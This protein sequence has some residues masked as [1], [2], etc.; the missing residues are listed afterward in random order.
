M[1]YIDTPNS[2]HDFASFLNMD[3]NDRII[4]S[5]GFGIGKTTFLEHYFKDVQAQEKYFICKLY[6]INYVTSENKDIYELIKYDILLQLLK[7]EIDITAE[8]LEGLNVG[9]K[10]NN[11]YFFPVLKDLAGIIPVIG[12][13]LVSAVSAIEKIKNASIEYLDK[14]P[15]DKIN[16]FL[17]E[18]QEQTGSP[19]EQ[20]DI[21]IFIK[22][23]INKIKDKGKR[24]VLI[25]DDFDRLEPAQTFRLLNILSTNDKSVVNDSGLINNENRFGFDKIIIVCDINNLRN[26]Y[27]HINGSSF[28]G[29]IDKFYSKNIYHFNPMQDLEN[30]VSDFFNMIQINGENINYFFKAYFNVLK[31]LYTKQYI[32][33]RS[34]SKLENNIIKVRERVAAY[35]PIPLFDI[36]FIVLETAFATSRDVAEIIDKSIEENIQLP[37]MNCEIV[38]SDCLNHIYRNQEDCDNK[39]ITLRDHTYIFQ[40]SISGY[41]REW[42]LLSVDSVAAYAK[43]PI[44]IFVFIQ[45]A[46]KAVR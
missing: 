3:G 13:N 29:Y 20:N 15:D 18:Y 1:K 12:E 6:P 46:K 9:T 27:I 41:D 42:R 11:K 17:K 34:F 26:S 4:F 39:P 14:N 16:S 10:M 36:F 30:S 25:I 22:T 33:I 19:Y 28:N 21:S 24:T 43:I 8:D 35:T 5:G 38:M 37:Y 40:I 7:P 32:T 44:P 31:L 45:E 23:V 2:T